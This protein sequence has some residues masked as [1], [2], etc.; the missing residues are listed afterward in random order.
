MKSSLKHSLKKLIATFSLGFVAFSV[1]QPMTAKAETT[2]GTYKAKDPDNMLGVAADFGIFVR[3]TFS[4][5]A[6]SNS[7]FACGQLSQGNPRRTNI[8][9]T[10][11]DGRP[12]QEA[13]N[14]VKGITSDVQVDCGYLYL[15]K[16]K[17]TK[18]K[19]YRGQN[20]ININNGE[21][22]VDGYIVAGSGNML[23]EPIIA[24][25]Y[26]DL[27]T[28][29]TKLSALANN[30]YKLPD[31]TVD[32]SEFGKM[33]SR[34]LKCNSDYNVINLKAAD[35]S[36]DS[37]GIYIQGI[38]GN[39][40]LIVN[41]DMS[42]VSKFDFTREIFLGEKNKP[43]S[44]IA[45][46]DKDACNIIWNFNNFSGTIVRKEK[47]AGIILAPNADVVTES[48][49]LIGSVIAKNYI[50][51]GSEVHYVP[52]NHKL[53]SVQVS[54]TA[55]NG[56]CC[57]DQSKVSRSLPGVEFAIFT[58]DGKKVAGSE[59]TTQAISNDANIATWTL[60]QPGKYYIQE[61]KTVQG[62]V[63]TPIKAR[64]DVVNNNGILQ[65]EKKLGKEANGY[66]AAY[67]K[68]L[69]AFKIRHYSNEV[70]A[71]AFDSKNYKLL[72]GT[73]FML[74]DDEGN[75]VKD[76]DGNV[77]TGVTDAEG[78]FVINIPKPG[79]YR[80]IQTETKDGYSIPKNC[81]RFAIY[82][83]PI[84]HEMVVELDTKTGEETLGILQKYYGAPSTMSKITK[85][86]N[87]EL[88][89]YG[90]KDGV[91]TDEYNAATDTC[92]VFS[93]DMIRK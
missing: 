65:V 17:I 89:A 53:P 51:N 28:E 1:M 84:G 6:H 86:F 10:K 19:V 46:Y 7:N 77:I 20:L 63:Q 81:V 25:K 90:Y 50:H 12:D 54:V 11:P 29:F 66:C 92:I 83:T 34:T 36:A 79:Y 72:E 4:A 67:D 78:V 57:D 32:K 68:A 56:N 37:E 38:R 16:G 49:L 35:L 14:Y 69:D 85:K 45:D 60:T 24:P 75:Q 74:T 70:V 27:E 93:N 59:K 58:L 2:T 82:H 18:D 64:F 43:D 61:T 22:N 48:G 41:V 21:W 31:Q 73:S 52:S 26:V 55:I 91:M 39:K 47:T 80:L 23:K 5:I 8:T 15:D 33:N 3:D 88:K 71:V 87:Q 30:L 40:L 62:F 76:D 42:G 9:A 13:V 44:Q